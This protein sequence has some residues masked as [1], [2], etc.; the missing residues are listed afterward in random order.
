MDRS[1]DSYDKEFKIVYEWLISVNYSEILD[2][3]T[4]SESGRPQQQ[5]IAQST[6]LAKYQGVYGD[7]QLVPHRLLQIYEREDPLEL[8]FILIQEC[9]L[10]LSEITLSHT[11]LA[12]TIESVFPNEDR[13]EKFTHVL[14]EFV[15]NVQ[16]LGLQ[17]DERYP[18]R[19]LCRTILEAI[20]GNGNNCQLQILFW[21]DKKA[22]IDVTSLSPSLYTLP[23]DP[24]LPKYQNLSAL[25][26]IT[27][28]F[29]PLGESVLHLDA[30]LQ[31]QVLLKVILL[32]ISF[33]ES[34]SSDIHRLFGTIGSLFSRSH[35]QVFSL[36]HD[37][38]IKSKS[39]LLFMRGFLT[40]PCPHEQQLSYDIESDSE[41]PN[42]DVTKIASLDLGTDM[43]PPCS[44]EH[45][46][47]LT[48]SDGVFQLLLHF[49]HL[50]L[51]Q[52]NLELS[53]WDESDQLHTT[54]IHPDLQVT[55][56]RLATFDCLPD[57]ACDD[58]R[59]LLRMLTLTR[60]I[61]TG[62]YTS[63]SLPPL[64]Q[65]LAELKKADSLHFLT[66]YNHRYEV[67][68]SRSEFVE[69]FD[70]IFSLSQLS[71]LELTISGDNLL[72]YNMWKTISNKFMRVGSIRPQVDSSS[73]SSSWVKV[74]NEILL[75]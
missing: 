61:I 12:N 58:M 72:S 66:L 47:F 63:G 9:D 2:T 20:I 55:N 73:T 10:H 14:K 68:C 26:L 27:P 21:K 60:L 41:P 6:T 57:T 3:S 18:D 44:L 52:V 38:S 37:D 11:Y 7:V 62:E 65:G 64:V 16:V 1:S 69:L 53:I 70:V 56:L 39:S 49:P 30:L 34:K 54:A 40:S 4:I 5:W 45:K 35:F 29:I 13:R 17:S 51:K 31:Q 36:N 8:F 48:D 59:A 42:M 24:G 67:S 23:C 32:K 43:I 19:D 28:I 71:D 50:W 74:M 46:T 22:G 33:K 15:R 25:E 75:L